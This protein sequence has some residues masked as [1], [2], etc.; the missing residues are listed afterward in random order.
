M[1][2]CIKHFYINST[3]KEAFKDFDVS[4]SWCLVNCCVSIHVNVQ[5]RQPYFKEFAYDLVE[6]LVTCP[7]QRSISAK[8]PSVHWFLERIKV[9]FVSGGWA[10]ASCFFFSLLTANVACSCTIRVEKSD[11]LLVAVASSPE[12]GIPSFFVEEWIGSSVQEVS[13]FLY[14][15][16]LARCKQTHI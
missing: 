1:R 8:F 13:C 14:L 10:T 6:T 9:F 5:G 4:S 12:Y 15:I 3:R 2:S 11:H 7:V 16:I